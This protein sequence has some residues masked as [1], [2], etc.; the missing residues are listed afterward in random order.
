MK[1]GL[2]G[3]GAIA[4]FLLTEINQNNHDKLRITSV[5]VRNKEKYQAL[6][7]E[8]GITLFTDIDHFLDSDIDIVAETATVEAAENS[9]PKIIKKKDLVLISIGALVDETILKETIQLDRKSTRLNSS[10]VAISYA[11]FCLKKKKSKRMSA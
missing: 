10:H 11:V 3:A 6:E 2:I 4:N 7:E 5:F 9:L 1:I 8:F